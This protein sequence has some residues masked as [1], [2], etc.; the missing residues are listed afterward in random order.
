M[1]RLVVVL[2]LCLTSCL[3][4]AQTASTSDAQAIKLATQ[5]VAALTGGVSVTDVTLNSTVIWI[6]GSDNLTGTA[7]LQ[8]KGNTESRVDLTLGS[9][10]RTEIR[11]STSGVPAG[12]WAND[13]A[14]PKASAQHNCWSDAAWFFPALSSLTQVSNAHFVFSYVGLEKHRGA[15][16]QH[17]RLMQALALDPQSSLAI[18]RLSA[19]DFYLDSVSLLPLAIAFKGHPDDNMGVDIPVEILFAGYQ[20]VSGVQVPFHIQRILNG[21]VALDITVTNVAIN[22]GLA[23]T[24]F[25]LQ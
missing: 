15:S 23:A 12:S 3:S 18:R 22:T 14:A 2:S 8:A 13:S 11:T 7:T 6:A 20:S 19:M 9:K 5:A 21:S 10:A 25:S 1:A 16:T 4:L 24:S 17:L